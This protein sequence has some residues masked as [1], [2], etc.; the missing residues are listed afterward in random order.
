MGSKHR[1]LSSLMKV[2]VNKDSR[3][4]LDQNTSD[5]GGHHYSLVGEDFLPAAITI[6]HQL[7]TP[8]RVCLC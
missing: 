3:F 5:T 8:E 2:R 6:S 1:D 7:N 4:F